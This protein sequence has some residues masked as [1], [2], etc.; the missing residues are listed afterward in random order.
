VSTL[1]PLVPPMLQTTTVWR[2]AVCVPITRSVLPPCFWSAGGRQNHVVLFGEVNM[3]FPSQFQRQ[4]STNTELVADMMD[5]V[6][7]L[8]DLHERHSYSSLSSRRSEVTQPSTPAPGALPT[9]PE[10]PGVLTCE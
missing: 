8:D 1:A 10:T 9:G 5:D 4:P 7:N 3:C 2:L 6:L